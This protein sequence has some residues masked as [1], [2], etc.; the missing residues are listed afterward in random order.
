MIV[1]R[2]QCKYSSKDNPEHNDPKMLILHTETTSL[3]LQSYSRK[4]PLYDMWCQ[5]PVFAI[6]ARHWYEA[7]CGTDQYWDPWIPPWVVLLQHYCYVPDYL[8]TIAHSSQEIVEP[9]QGSGASLICEA[10]MPYL[11]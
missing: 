6:V 10:C 3:Q 8:P 1:N 11:A 2:V 4:I 7:D 9:T 5:K